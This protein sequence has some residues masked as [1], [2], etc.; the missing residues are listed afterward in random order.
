MSG[1]VKAEYKQTEAGVIP[2]NW[3]RR[4]KTSSHCDGGTTSLRASDAQVQY[5]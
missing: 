3:I 2:L 5:Q 4:S 1:E